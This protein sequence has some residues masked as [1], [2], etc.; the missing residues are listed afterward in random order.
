MMDIDKIIFPVDLSE[1]TNR[2]VPYVRTMASKL[3]AKI[4]IL[5][6][7]SGLEYYTETN[8]SVSGTSNLE[9][10]IEYGQKVVDDFRVL[11]F[12]D[13]PDTEAFVITDGVEEISEHVG[14]NEGK[15]I[16]MGMHGSAPRKQYIYGSVAD[17]V[18]TSAPVPILIVNTFQNDAWNESLRSVNKM[19]KH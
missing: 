12:R 3:K 10:L 18:I 9:S 15:M 2:T 7:I 19:N 5:Y 16:I 1:T 14:K 8:R 11:H 6:V 4:D 13:F 17:H